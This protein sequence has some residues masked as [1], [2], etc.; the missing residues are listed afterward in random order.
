MAYGIFKVEG[1]W[2][3]AISV[4]ASLDLPA[5]MRKKIEEGLKITPSTLCRHRTTQRLV[6]QAFA[7][8]GTE[9]CH[10]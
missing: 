1:A 4:F 8:S 9:I 3:V 7:V 10:G 2:K 6:I 5:Q